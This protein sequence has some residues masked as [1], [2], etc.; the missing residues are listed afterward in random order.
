MIGGVSYLEDTLNPRKGLASLHQPKQPSAEAR[1]NRRAAVT[2]PVST[3]VDQ[4]AHAKKKGEEPVD[5]VMKAPEKVAEAPQ[6]IDRPGDADVKPVHRMQS[7]H[8]APRAIRSI[9][10]LIALAALATLLWF[11]TRSRNS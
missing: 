4:L 1:T 2:I 6:T 7:P 5:R 10:L 3:L 11:A 8:R 9:I